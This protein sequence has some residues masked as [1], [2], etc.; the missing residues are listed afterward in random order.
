MASFH[1]QGSNSEVDTKQ[2]IVSH[3]HAIA[4]R[5]RAALAE[6]DNAKFSLVLCLQL[7]IYLIFF[8]T[9]GSM[10]KSVSLQV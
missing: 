9:V 10:P 7:L 6:I 4:E 8:L 5:R 1:E 2:P 3:S